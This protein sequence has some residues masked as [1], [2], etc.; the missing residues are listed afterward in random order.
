MRG[1]TI[2][3]RRKPPFA[4]L[5]VLLPDLEQLDRRVERACKEL[6][7][8]LSW[9]GTPC[10]LP[11]AGVELPILHGCIRCV[12]RGSRDARRQP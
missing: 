8:Q 4:S 9:I 7:W 2:H 12:E 1:G 5:A 3:H 10:I 11:V 6:P